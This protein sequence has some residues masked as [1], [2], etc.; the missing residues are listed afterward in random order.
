LA[1]ERLS[2]SACHWRLH[3]IK[4]QASLSLVCLS[5]LCVCVCVSSLWF[6]CCCFFQPKRPPKKE[7]FT[8]RCDEH[9]KP[10]TLFP[11]CSLC[12][13][14]TLHA[15]GRPKLEVSRQ[16]ESERESET[17]GHK[18][19]RNQFPAM[20]VFVCPLD[21]I[22]LAF[23]GTK[24]GRAQEKQ[25]TLSGA[26][27]LTLPARQDQPN[28]SLCINSNHLPLCPMG[29]AR[30]LKCASRS[31]PA[32]LPSGRKSELAGWPNCA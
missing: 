3:A 5:C 17:G 32:A 12:S 7:E 4:L 26:L 1:N 6:V 9:H 16:T 30:Q 23:A 13:F 19:E 21:K 18:F 20:I 29:A 24:R 22:A 10:S 25:C 11:L 27:E 31:S 8:R 14:F 28:S 15:N 2:C